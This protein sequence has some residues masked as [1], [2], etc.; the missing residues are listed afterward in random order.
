MCGMPCAFLMASTF[1]CKTSDDRG[2]ALRFDASLHVETV[3]VKRLAAERVRD[4]L[5]LDDEEPLIC[6]VQRVEAID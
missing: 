2:P 1:R 4:F 5:A 3:D 6:A